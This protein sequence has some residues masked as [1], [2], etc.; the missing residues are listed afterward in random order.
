[1]Y[2]IYLIICVVVVAFLCGLGLGY[3]LYKPT[4]TTFIGNTKEIVLRDTSI[5]IER[6]TDTVLQTKLVPVKGTKVIQDVSIKIVPDTTVKIDTMIIGDTVYITKTIG[7]DTIEVRMAIL[8]DNKTQ[9]LTV[10]AKAINGTIVGA[11]Q[12][13]KSDLVFGKEFKH[14]LGAYG[15]Y[16][17]RDGT[18]IVGL[19]YNRG[20]GPFFI[21]GI[22]GTEIKKWDN[23][24]VGLSAGIRW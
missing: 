20:I 5:I 16:T 24:N 14:S 9:T 13:P 21:G 12:V 1:M 19:N 11:I 8:K 7:C 2:K 23:I 6:I 17:P 15:T 22:V 3:K 4:S 10:Q 18:S